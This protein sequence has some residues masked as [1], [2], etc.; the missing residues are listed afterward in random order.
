MYET[1]MNIYTNIV[2]GCDTSLGNR[3]V[4]DE[5]SVR[6]KINYRI[7]DSKYYLYVGDKCITFVV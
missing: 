6:Y 4:S 2:L 3:N 1:S 5:D 7:Y